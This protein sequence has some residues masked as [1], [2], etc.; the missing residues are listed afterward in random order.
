[1]KSFKKAAI[2]ILL[3][4]ALILSSALLA[5]SEEKTSFQVPSGNTHKVKSLNGSTSILPSAIRKNAVPSQKVIG[6]ISLGLNGPVGLAYDAANGDIYQADSGD[7][8]VA[9]IN[10]TTDNLIANI[11]VG[12]SPTEVAY[13]S[14]NGKL[15]VTESN[16]I[17]VIDTSSNTVD[18]QIK[19]GEWAAYISFDSRNGCFY[20]S[21]PSTGLNPGYVLVING[22]TNKP[23][24]NLTS[25][26]DPYGSV[27]DGTNGYVYVA[28]Q[29]LQGVYII[30]DTTNAIARTVKLGADALMLAYDSFNQRVYLTD[31]NRITVFNGTSDRV[32]GNFSSVSLDNGIAVDSESGNLFIENPSTGYIYVVNSKTG[33]LEKSLDTNG[34]PGDIIFDPSNGNVYASVPP[35]SVYVLN[36]STGSIEKILEPGTYPDAVA[37][38]RA[39]GE[40]YVTNLDSRRVTAINGTSNRQVA[41][42][43]VGAGPAGVTAGYHG[44]YVYVSDSSINKVS[45]IYAPTDQVVS[46]LKVGDSPEGIAFDAASEKVYVMNLNSQNVSVINGTTGPLPF[47]IN[48]GNYPVLKLFPD[49]VAWDSLNHNL[50]FTNIGMNIVSE[51]NTTS[52]E[53]VANIQVTSDT[54][55]ITTDTWNGFL[56]ITCPGSNTVSVVNTSTNSVTANIPVGA[57]PWAI[58]FDPYNGLI[59]VANRGSGNVSVI[60][61]T[62]NK[63]VASLNVG[64][65]PEGVAFDYSNGYIYVSNLRSNNIT[66][67]GSTSYNQTFRETGLPSGDWYVNITGTEVINSGPLNSSPYAV[68]LPNGT[69]YYNL[70]TDNGNFHAY[71]SSQEFRVNNSTVTYIMQFQADQKT[72]YSFLNVYVLS[73]IFIVAASAASLIMNYRRKRR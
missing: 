59:Y 1:M 31:G 42:V 49:E 3:S 69:Y 4:L 34:A 61:G 37:Y 11:S 64:D 2:S 52:N 20:V 25:V 16:W 12:P 71:R 39:N 5:I 21:F 65:T 56:Y 44:N 26:M 46:T 45:V 54:G 19:T 38:D 7:N 23:V 14:L 24:A 73:A 67:L 70:S 9:V 28:S 62:T 17:A 72:G 22:S 50:Y 13:D 15:Y 33:A 43:G 10:G 18:S 6:S 27:A 40:I 63:V 30:N 68:P 60:D 35:Y 41:T 55:A 66:I 58:S 29:Q 53:Q 48:V 47:P 36:G 32:V 8:R 51:I 57:S